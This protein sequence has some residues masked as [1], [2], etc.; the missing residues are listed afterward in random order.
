M[1]RSF[2]KANN[3]LAKSN[4]EWIRPTNHLAAENNRLLAEIL[5]RLIVL[6]KKIDAQ[7]QAR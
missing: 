5:Q 7:N 4:N 3:D 2:L 1:D 6:E